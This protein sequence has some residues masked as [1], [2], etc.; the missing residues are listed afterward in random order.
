[1]F[2]QPFYGGILWGHSWIYDQQS[3]LGLSRD[4]SILQGWTDGP[5]RFTAMFI[6]GENDF[7][8]QVMKD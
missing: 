6:H 4:G 7:L 3:G 5:P 1:M 2:D 8:N